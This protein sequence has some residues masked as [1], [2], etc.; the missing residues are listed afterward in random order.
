[1]NKS[2]RIAA[3]L[4][5]G[6]FAVS[7]APTAA[8]LSDDDVAILEELTESYRQAVLAGDAAAVA[9]MYTPDATEMPAN[10]PVREGGA[11]IL[12]AYEAQAGMMHE[13]RVTPV[14]THG[15]G[16]LAYQR[17]TWSGTFA[18]AGLAE[19]I[20]DTGKYL[21][22]AERQ[23]DGSWL[24]TAVIWNSDLPLPGQQ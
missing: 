4:L 5:A 9:A 24:W 2:C 16:D 23:E 6:F 11:A 20:A 13:F 15:V 8:P 10:F 3:L 14:A 21:E 17:G 22:I 12:A 7:C 1:M 19:A 18:M